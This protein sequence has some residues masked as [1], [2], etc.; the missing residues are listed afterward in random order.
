MAK[1]LDDAAV[2]HLVSKIVSS[3]KTINGQSLWG[4]ENLQLATSAQ[5]TSTA[6]TLSERI[7]E[8][9]PLVYTFS[10]LRQ[11]GHSNDSIFNSVTYSFKSN[12]IARRNF[13]STIY[14]S[15]KEAIQSGRRIIIK[16]NNYV[17]SGATTDYSDC[18]NTVISGANDQPN[19]TPVDPTVYGEVIAS[20]YADHSID[21]SIT[22]G[23]EF[24]ILSVAIGTSIRS[25]VTGPSFQ[26]T[27]GRLKI[28][29]LM[30]FKAETGSI[31]CIYNCP[32][33][34]S[35]PNPFS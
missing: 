3:T 23:K 13:S 2:E 10:G 25:N 6:N 32:V 35:D 16:D 5:L 28:G 19:F 33:D 24:I 12:N 11:I 18:I 9:K 14:N 7:N 31:T 27:I 22:D 30:L 8:L 34:E 29:T 26:N 17:S 1:F 4:S 20:S 15:I 21:S